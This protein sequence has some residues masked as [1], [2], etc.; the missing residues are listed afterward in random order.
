ME[1]TVVLLRHRRGRRGRILYSTLTSLKDAV[2][3]DGEYFHASMI[4]TSV[5]LCIATK[6]CCFLDLVGGDMEDLGEGLSLHR[7]DR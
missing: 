5:R 7:F 1:S 6:K 2:C 4:S 3:W